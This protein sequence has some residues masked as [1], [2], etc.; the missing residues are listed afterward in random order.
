LAEA[1]ITGVF[2]L[3]GMLASPFA[4]KKLD[5]RARLVYRT[6][7]TLGAG[8]WVRLGPPCRGSVGH[9]SER[10]ANAFVRGPGFS[11]LRSIFARPQCCVIPQTRLLGR[12][13]PS[14]CALVLEGRPG[15]SR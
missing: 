8:T 7:L 1:K 13:L 5:A 15:Y 12:A 10:P 3:P 2:A 9:L 4:G 14:A 11:L 6:R